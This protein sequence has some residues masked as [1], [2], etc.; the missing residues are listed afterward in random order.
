[1]KAMIC[2]KYGPPDVLQLEEVDKPTPKENEVLVK[3]RAASVNAGDWH[4]LRAKPFII[5]LG[6]GLIKPKYKILGM[7]IAGTVESVGSQVKG[8]KLGDEVFGDL[9]RCGFGAFAEY[10]CVPESKLAIK[11]ASISF[12]EAA[13]VPTAGVTA[14]QGLRDK[15]KIKAGQKVLINGASGG[16][17]TFAV[18]IAKRFGA[19]VT[20]VCSTR[21]V[22]LVSSL[23]ADHVID[24]TCDDFTKMGQCYDLILAVNGYHPISAYKRVLNPHGVYVMIGGT[25]VQMFQAMLAGPFISMSGK[26]MGNLLVKPNKKDL[27][28]MSYYLEAGE[29]VPVIDRSYPLSRLP[30]AIAY[31]EEG[32]AQGKVIIT[33]DE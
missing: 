4:L 26:Q 1:M 15:G 16:V 23:G 29:V 28:E 13:A 8:L 27:M 9:S 21:N 14:L 33:M 18:Q 2:T 11:P 31:L 24:Y 32:H 20:A 17:G 19:E 6:I 25:E 30:E 10:V 5:R 3:V 12:E 7:D 22:E